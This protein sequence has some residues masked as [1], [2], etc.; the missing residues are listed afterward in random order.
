MGINPFKF[1]INN[2]NSSLNVNNQTFQSVLPVIKKMIRQC[3][4][5]YHSKSLHQNCHSLNFIETDQ[6]RFGQVRSDLFCSFFEMI[7]VKVKQW[8][9]SL[10]I[11][12]SDTSSQVKCDQVKQVHSINVI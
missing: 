3:Y 6:V 1:K 11:Y 9:S 2:Q 5:L 4:N 8:R 12:L 10:R 7:K